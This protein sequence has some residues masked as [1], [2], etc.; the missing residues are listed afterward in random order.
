MALFIVV[1]LTLYALMHLLVF[2][3]VHP[4]L[5]GHPALPTL[6]LVWMGGMLLAPIVVR[7]LDRHGYDLVARGLAWVG[8]SWMGFLFLAFCLFAL[9]GVWDLAATGVARLV[10]ALPNLSIHGAQ[11]SVTVLLVVLAAGLYALYEASDLRIETIR[12]QTDKFPQGVERITVAQVSDIHIGLINREAVLAPIIARLAELE[13]N[14]VVATGDIVDAQIS[15]LDGLSAAWRTLEPPSGKYAVIGNHEVYAGLEQSLDFFDRCGFTV[16][17][18]RGETIHD[19]LTLVG[20]DDEAARTKEDVVLLLKENGKGLFT[21]FLKHRPVPEEGTEGLFDLQLSGHTHR[22]Q[23]FPFNY[24]TAIMFP[25]QD[26]LYTLLGGSRLYASRGTGTWGPPMRLFS[27]PE[28]T[29]FEIVTSS[30]KD[31]ESILGRH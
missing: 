11:G 27:P 6:T 7:V 5:S 8:Y 2:W 25:L 29:L 1:F 22:G 18:N 26:G 3:G 15:H 19:T 16:L 12:L 24:L 21:L 4:V 30:K 31:R 23:I 14:I 10:P 28:I 17:R 13:P 20:I 9:M